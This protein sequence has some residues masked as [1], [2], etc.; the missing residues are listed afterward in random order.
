M[1]AQ[2]ANDISEEERTRRR[3]ALDNLHRLR[4]E[5]AAANPDMSDEDWDRF[6][7]EWA[8]DVNE[9]L[10]DIVRRSRGEPTPTS[11]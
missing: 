10:R 8:E 5:I 6:A 3:T 1:S 2:R 7:D 4:E 11:H 9:G